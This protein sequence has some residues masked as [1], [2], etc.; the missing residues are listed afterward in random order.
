MFLPSQMDRKTPAEKGRRNPGEGRIGTVGQ[1]VGKAFKNVAEL[2]MQCVVLFDY[3]QR[4]GAATISL[5]N[6]HQS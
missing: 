5:S 1:I 3:R 4:V 6:V 2:Q